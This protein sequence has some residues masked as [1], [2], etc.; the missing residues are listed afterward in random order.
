M[1]DVTLYG[2]DVNSDN[3]INVTD[4]VVIAAG[5]GTGDPAT[6]IN[7]DGNVNITDLVGAAS[8]F[9]LSAPTLW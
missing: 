1:T 8:N 9:G 4:L 3:A 2:G 5:F 6:D 7:H